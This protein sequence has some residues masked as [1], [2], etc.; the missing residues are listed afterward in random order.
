M[1]RSSTRPSACRLAGDGAVLLDGV[2]VLQWG[3]AVTREKFVARANRTLGV[4]VG[5]GW[6]MAA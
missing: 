5:R 4:Q 6:G 2:A 3:P 1:W